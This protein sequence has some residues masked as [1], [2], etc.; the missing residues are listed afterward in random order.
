[1]RL[2]VLIQ[3]DAFINLVL[4]ESMLGPEF[5]DDG[6]RREKLDNLEKGLYDGLFVNIDIPTLTDEAKFSS[7]EEYLT[8]LPETVTNTETKKLTRPMAMGGERYTGRL[9]EA[10]S[11]LQAVFIHGMN[12]K[13]DSKKRCIS[14]VENDGIVFIDEIDKIVMSPVG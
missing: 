10:R 12:N 1:M 3:L 13:I 9:H 2:V 6:I 4:L 7:I 5:R 11:I 14:E 8:S